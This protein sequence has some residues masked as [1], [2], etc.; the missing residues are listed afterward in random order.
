MAGEWDFVCSWA[1]DTPRKYLE[2]PAAS[3]SHIENT[4]CIAPASPPPSISFKKASHRQ[5]S[6]VPTLKRKCFACS[7]SYHCDAM[8]SPRKRTRTQ[9]DQLP[10]TTATSAL[11][12]IQLPPT[13]QSRSSSPAKVRANSP[14]RELRDIYRFATPPLKY[15]TSADENTPASVLDLI[16]MLPLHGVGVIPSSLKV[17]LSS[18][19]SYV[20]TSNNRCA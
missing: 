1:S 12:D 14:V 5:T 9:D 6:K 18:L 2:A 11:S 8:P 13:V 16:R 20:P 10:I 19:R 3:I 17:R 7:D 4:A 15:T